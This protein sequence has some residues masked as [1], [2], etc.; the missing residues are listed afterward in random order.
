MA[1]FRTYKLIIIVSVIIGLCYSLPNI[2]YSST[3]QSNRKYIPLSF[4][5]LLY[6]AQVKEVLDGNIFVGDPQFFEHKNTFLPVFP[7]IPVYLLSLLS[8][9]SGSVTS[10]FLLADFLF[11]ALLFVLVH[12]L[13]L[14]VTKNYWFSLFSSIAILTVYPLL[15]KI[16]PLSLQQLKSSLASILLL[17]V[18]K[19]LPFYRTP[20]PQISFIVLTI[21]LILSYEILIKPK[22]RVII[23]TGLV[24]ALLFS[25]Y[26]YHAVFFFFF[27]GIV[28]FLLV[29]QK[30]KSV[31]IAF[32]LIMLFVALSGFALKVISDAPS[33]ATLKIT[34][35][36][37]QQRYIDWLFTL[38]Y[39][40]LL[41]AVLLL[42]KRLPSITFNYLIALSGS[43]ILCM[44]FQILSGWTIQPGHWPQTTLEP[45]AL[46]VLFLLIFYLLKSA[47]RIKWYQLGTMFI[48][49]YAFVSQFRFVHTHPDVWTINQD[50]GRVLEWINNYGDENTVVTSLNVDDLNYIPVLTRANIFVPVEQYHYASIDEIWQRIL[51]NYRLYGFEKLPIE[52]ISYGVHFE[53][54]YN[55]QKYKHYSF[56]EY[57]QTTQQE[58]RN[59]YPSL[60]STLYALPTSIKQKYG[61]LYRETSV[62]QNPYRL[63]LALYTPYEKNLGAQKPFGYR[64]FTSGDYE[65]YQLMSK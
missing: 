26:F 49:I 54:A 14:R 3:V 43:A 51:F 8:F 7:L 31:A 36:V 62:E 44:N 9:L 45:T 25:T 2:Y 5:E 46:I 56:E 65:I 40:L 42:R 4:S 59:C 53:L 57:D 29:S 61:E 27:V 11:P 30:R 39:G 37:F 23:L 60:C 41:L 55:V 22:R 12:C 21:A 13:F 50:F 19:P 6:G 63:D 34:G 16:T 10:G 33:Y 64:V 52:T 15:S 17:S 47:I 32:T 35:G 38:R 48:L 24:G 20:N 18:D 28:I 58:I 1:F